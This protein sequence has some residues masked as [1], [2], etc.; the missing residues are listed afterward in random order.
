MSMGWDYVSELRPPACLLFIPNVACEHGEPW[1]NDTDRAK[2]LIRPPEISGNPTSSHLTARVRAKETMNLAL[3]S[4]VVRTFQVIS[5]HAVKSYDMGLLA[6]LPLQRKVFCRFFIA[7]KNPSLWPG[8]NPRTFGLV[9]ST[10]TVTSPRRQSY[11]VTVLQENLRS[12]HKTQR[13]GVCWEISA[14]LHKGKIW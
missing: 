9:A 1:W 5:L 6:L 12:P 2:L 3:R 4:I 13:L 14:D 7:L 10:R 11:V 8:L